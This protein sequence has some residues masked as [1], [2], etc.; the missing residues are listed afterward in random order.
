MNNELFLNQSTKQYLKRKTLI[1]LT[2]NIEVKNR[3]STLKKIKDFFGFQMPSMEI[4]PERENEIIE[5]TARFVSRLGMEWP[6]ILIGSG[7][8]PVSTILAQTTLLPLAPLLELVGIRG[9]EYTAFFEKKDNV[10][11]LLER[12]DELRKERESRE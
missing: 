2:E 1:M 6:A 7:Y 4:S 9:F 5:K 3:M 8:V 11:R 12:I 10:K